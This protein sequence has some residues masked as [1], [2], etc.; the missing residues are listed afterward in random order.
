MKATEEIT[1]QICDAIPELTPELLAAVLNAAG[2][3]CQ[4]LF[5]QGEGQQ[6]IK[7]KTHYPDYLQVEI[8]DPREAMNL[9]QQL[10]NACSAAMDNGGVLRSPVTL[11]F[12]GQALLSE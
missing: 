12:A 5:I 11:S 8:T 2:E 4:I 6:V 7:G 1:T 10:L 3:D 9:A